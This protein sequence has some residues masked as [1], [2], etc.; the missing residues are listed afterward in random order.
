[1]H[2]L[3]CKIPLYNIDGSRN[4]A[5]SIAHFICLRLWVEEVKEWWEFLVIELGSENMV[6]GLPWLRSTNL[7]IDW[8]EGTIK[9]ENALTD[10][11]VQ[12]HKGGDVK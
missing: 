3:I 2:P 6:L 7:V 5:G 8:T 10:P 1:M 11:K 4:K 9:V 12:P